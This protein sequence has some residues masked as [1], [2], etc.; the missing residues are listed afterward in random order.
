[1]FSP[2]DLCPQRVLSGRGGPWEPPSSGKLRTCPGSWRNVFA[3]LSRP[4][5]T[6]ATS[7]RSTRIGLPLKGSRWQLKEFPTAGKAP[8]VAGRQEREVQ[9]PQE[10]RPGGERGLGKGPRG[11]LC[12]DGKLSENP[13]LR[14]Q[15]RPAYWFVLS[16]DTVFVYKEHLY[17]FPFG[18]QQMSGVNSR[19][20]FTDQF[21]LHTRTFP[22]QTVLSPVCL[23]PCSPRM[24]VPSAA[25]RRGCPHRSIRP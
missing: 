4:Q 2:D 8:H 20:R 24:G 16:Q 5:G 3:D 22:P 17:L 6:R 12:L 15:F 9:A 11:S 21:H 23:L 14:F 19:V 18:I 13:E 10:S 7:S 25:R 1:M